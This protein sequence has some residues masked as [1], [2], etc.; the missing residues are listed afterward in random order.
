ME[1]ARGNLWLCA[2]NAVLRVKRALIEKWRKKAIPKLAYETYDATHGMKSALF[3][4]QGAVGSRA[5]NGRLWFATLG[6]LVTVD[7]AAITKNDW[8]LPVMIED[9]L[10]DRRRASRDELDRLR[11]GRGDIEVRYAGLSYHAPERV[12]FRYR[13]EGFDSDW[14]DAGSRRVAFYTNVPPGKY[15]FKV[16]ACNS[17]GVWNEKGASLDIRLLP[18][19]YQ[20]TWFAA[21]VGATLIGGVMGLHRLRVRNHLRLE[22]M[23]HARIEE[24]VAHIKT[25]RGLLP[26]CA[27][28]RKVR[29]DSGYWGRLDEYVSEHTDAEFSHGI[30][31]ECRERKFGRRAE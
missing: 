30:C 12:R 11:P 27:W 20:T 19:F 26:I 28:C 4:Y 5:S 22:R 2:P 3:D 6:G 8:V 17:D 23:L 10:V 14:V 31:P 1:D 29:D 21:L 16:K 7:P 25:L 24:A 9:V 18:H 15:V 13:L